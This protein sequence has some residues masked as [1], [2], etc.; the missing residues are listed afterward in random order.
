MVINLMG[1][2]A[3]VEKLMLSCY[4]MG[5]WDYD[6]PGY[7]WGFSENQINCPGVFLKKKYYPGIGLVKISFSTSGCGWSFFFL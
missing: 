5:C 1:I 2:K 3:A 4:K 6:P 7:Y